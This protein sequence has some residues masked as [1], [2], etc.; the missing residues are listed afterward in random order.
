MPKL[1]S[2][3][4]LLVFGFTSAQPP[5]MILNAGGFKAIDVSIPATKPEKLVSLTKTWATERERRRIDQDKGYDFTDVTNNTITV[6]GFKKN[7]FYYTNLGEQFEH[8]IEYT[9]KLTFYENH[10]T[11]AFNVTQIYIDNNVPVQSTLADYFKGDGT[12]KEGYTNLDTSLEATVNT[13]VQSHYDTLM[14]YR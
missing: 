1:Y 8:R 5:K 12:L 4:C 3:F 2:L 11:L 13:I 7:A 6:T 14:N 9:M 10:Y